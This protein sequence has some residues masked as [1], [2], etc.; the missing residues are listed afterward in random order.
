MIDS[1][2]KQNARMRLYRARK[3]EGVKIAAQVELFPDTQSLLIETGLASPEEISDPALL[4][5]IV[6]DILDCWTRSALSPGMP[7]LSRN[8]QPKITLGAKQK[9]AIVFRTNKEHLTHADFT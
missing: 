7:A 8:S 9:H 5:L 1:R 3:K 6:S 4:S 2:E